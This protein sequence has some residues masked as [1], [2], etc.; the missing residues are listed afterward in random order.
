ML[1]MAD[2]IFD[3]RCQLTPDLNHYCFNTCNFPNVN[4]CNT[5]KYRNAFSRY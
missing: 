5:Y 1:L 2:M 3:H 4:T